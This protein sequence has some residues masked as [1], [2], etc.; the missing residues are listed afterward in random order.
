MSGAV[1]LSRLVR[2]TE[3]AAMLDAAAGRPLAVLGPDGALVAGTDVPDD[4]VAVVRSDGTPLGAVAGPG[5][6][7]GAAVLSALVAIEEE[8]RQLAD[9]VLGLYREVNL[10]YALAENLS[11]AGDREDLAART[12]REA[13]RLVPADEGAV[14]VDDGTPSIAAATSSAAPALPEDLTRARID[15]DEPGAVL[16]APLALGEVR[17]GAL[18]LR[19]R[20]GGFSAADLKLL[21]AVAAQAA[22]VLER[23]LEE[24][25]RSREAA[26]REERLRRQIEELRIELDEARQAEQVEQITETDYFGSLRA[27]ASDLRRIITDRAD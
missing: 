27:Q 21:G 12:L 26:E 9:E 14:A 20:A 3:V 22:S 24:E 13:T 1:R 6:P 23:I 10:L 7:V 2:R 8:R 4:P 19:R 25:R 17:R 18:V 11:Q 5:A 15:P 16:V